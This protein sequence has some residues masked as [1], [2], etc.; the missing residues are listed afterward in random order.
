M[1]SIIVRKTKTSINESVLDF[2][3]NNCDKGWF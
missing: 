2:K 1:T 3:H